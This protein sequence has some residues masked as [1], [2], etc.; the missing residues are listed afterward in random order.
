MT[1][2]RAKGSSP[3]RTTCRSV[4]EW[5][6]DPDSAF[7]NP[8][9]ADLEHHVVLVCA[10]GYSSSLA[11]ATLQELGF[12]RA[13]DLAGGFRAWKADGL[14]IVPAPSPDGGRPGMGASAPSRD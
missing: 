5:R 13:T 12:T 3:A 1:S 4:L 10:D 9:L 11:A 14:P 2:G 7:R 6:L 8:A